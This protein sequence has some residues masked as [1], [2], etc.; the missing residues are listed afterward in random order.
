MEQE[1]LEGRRALITGADS[2]IGAAVS[3]AFVRSR[4]CA[5]LLEVEQEDAQHVIQSDRD[6]GRK[7]RPAAG[8]IRDKRFATVVGWC[9]VKLSLVVLMHW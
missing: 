2:G 5:E 3:I 1:R 7:S 4:C 6:S 9:P 8:D